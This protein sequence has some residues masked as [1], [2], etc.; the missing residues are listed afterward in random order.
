MCSLRVV[1]WLCQRISELLSVG[2]DDRSESVERLALTRDRCQQ[3]GC[4]YRVWTSVLG[5]AIEQGVSQQF[6]GEHGFK[7]RRGCLRELID[8]LM[9]ESTASRVATR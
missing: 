6:V 1:R 2:L 3:D 4:G 9:G 8:L 7:A 5:H